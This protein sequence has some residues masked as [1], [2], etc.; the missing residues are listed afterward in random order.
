MT[1]IINKIEYLSE[2]EKALCEAGKGSSYIL[3][4]CN[5]AAKLIDSNLPVIFD[6]KHLALLIGIE[7][8]DLCK[9]IWAVD[10]YLYR[11]ASIPKKSGA[12]RNLLIPCVTLKYIQRWILDNI[13]YKLHVSKQSTGFCKKKSILS[14]AQIHVGMECVINLDIKNFFPTISVEQVFRI[15]HYYGYT[16]E[17]SYTLAKLCTFQ[18]YL[19]QGSPASPCL[20]NIVC[21]KLDKRLANLATKYS[22]NYTRYAD[23]ITFSGNKR[24]VTILDIAKNIIVQEG[25]CINEEKQRILYH[26]QRQVVT[27]LVVNQ[28]NVKVLKKYKRNLQTEIYFCKKFGVMSHQQKTQ[29]SHNFYK[30]HLYGKAYFINMVEPEIGQKLLNQLDEIVWDY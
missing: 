19:P 21:L 3:A 22:A 15:F 8:N 16:K 5:Y 23:D 25:F 17:V 13:L 26:H 27:G 11:E 18:G 14:N 12:K 20:S 28:T 6:I 1:E 2:L 29:D 4:C 30:E 9:V 24:I 10:K 7:P